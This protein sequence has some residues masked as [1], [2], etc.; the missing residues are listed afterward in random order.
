[1]KAVT[2]VVR[3]VQFRIVGS[4]L[5]CPSDEGFRWFAT[6][7]KSSSA[8]SQSTGTGGSVKVLDKDRG[9]SE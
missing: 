9:S 1:M 8:I 5:V 7:G 6:G 2:L 4:Q 3:R